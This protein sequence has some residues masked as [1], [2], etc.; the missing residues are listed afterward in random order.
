VD[1]SVE[2][3]PGELRPGLVNAHDHLHRNHFPRL[4][5]PPYLD[6]Y[7]WG[8]DIHERWAGEVARGRAVARRDAL[9]FGA[10]KNL[11]AGATTVVHHDP[12]EPDFDRRF[13]VRVAR[14]R[15]AHS[16]GFEPELREAYRGDP[17]LPLCIHLAEGATAEAADEVRAL[18]QLG[19]V[20][21]RL[22]AVHAVAVDD[23]GIARLRGAGA[24]VVW[25]PTS[26]RFL[27]GRTA[28][29]ALLASG[30][31]V[32]VGS[33]S[34][35]TGDGTL[36]DELRTARSLGLVPDRGL[37]DGV[38]ATAAR[39]LRLPPPELAPGAPADLVHLARPPLD[40]T[41]EDVRL[42]LVAGVPRLGDEAFAGLFERCGVAVERLRVGRTIKLVAAPLAEVAG[43]VV[44]DWPEAG[45]IL[46]PPH[47]PGRAAAS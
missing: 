21:G 9:L 35:L 5:E 28:P 17:G 16:L 15:A 37:L 46:E 38:G 8:R 7:A 30:I 4:G 23:D 1:L 41:A 32:L 24:A 22:V 2:L 19:L 3:G 45:R 34:L 40:A 18:D 43:R 47:G 12:W 13:P 10:L 44:G 26:N 42:V 25:C 6:A 20:D 27:F 36:L 39:R 11:L 33:D 29:A 31:D 14:V